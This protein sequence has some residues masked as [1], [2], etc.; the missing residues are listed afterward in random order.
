MDNQKPDPQQAC[1]AHVQVVRFQIENAGRVFEEQWRC[2]DC[3]AKF[4]NLDSFFAGPQRIEVMEPIAT[5]RDQLAMAALTGMLADENVHVG[6]TYDAKTAEL[7][8]GI[9]D[10]MMEARKQ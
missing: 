8:Y 1:C 7:C 3:G 6:G 10:A 9:A 5:L 4:V 2:K